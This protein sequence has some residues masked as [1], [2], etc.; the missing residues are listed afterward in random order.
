[1]SPT[2]HTEPKISLFHENDVITEIDAQIREERRKFDYTTK[3][4]S[5]GELVRKLETTIDEQVEPEN[6]LNEIYIPFYQRAFVWEKDQQSEFIESLLIGIPIPLIFL[7]EVKPHFAFEVVD[8]SQRIRTLQSF[9]N[10]ELILKGL[11]LLSKLNNL[12]FED[13]PS[14][15]QRQF[16]NISLRC[17]VLADA[18]DEKARRLLFQRI[19]ATG[20]LLTEQQKRKGTFPDVFIDFIYNDCT[21]V[22]GFPIDR[23]TQSAKAKGEPEELLLRFFAFIYDYNNYKGDL[24]EFLDV[25]LR[26]RTDFSDIPKKQYLFDLQ[27]V[28]GFVNQ[29]FKYGFAT[30]EKTNRIPR[31]RFE[32]LSVGTY[33][34]LQHKPDLIPAD[35]DWAY[36]EE[37]NKLVSGI[38]SA[39][40]ENVQN[41]INFVCRMLSGSN[42]PFVSSTKESISDEF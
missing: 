6:R 33:F 4:F 8:G 41:R 24:S 34:A 35:T 13:L 39:K 7:A 15:Y 3:E 37:F 18:N 10:G 5:I 25:F 22:V 12:K 38:N 21:K 26:A 23:F 14:N 31:I 19:N 27:Q 36:G 42:S 2:S 16:R 32:A 30:D 9:L 40:K 20:T 29:H 17:I 28:L 1:M 11:K